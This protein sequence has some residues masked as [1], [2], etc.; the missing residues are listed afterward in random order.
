MV[1]E[2][3]GRRARIVVGAKALVLGDTDDGLHVSFEIDRTLKPEPNTAEIRIWNL[4]ESSRKLLEQMAGV[5]PLGIPVSVEAGYTE[6]SLLFLGSMREAYS[7]TQWADIV[8]TIRT[9]EGEQAYQ[10]S[11]ANLS[12]PRGT[13]ITAALLQLAAQLGVLPG[14]LAAQSYQFIGGSTVFANGAVFSGNAAWEITSLLSACGKE[15][16]IQ[17]GQIQVLDRNKAML[18]TAVFM[19]AETGMIDAPSISNKGELQARM[20]LVPDVVPGRLLVAKSRHV[21]GTFRIE[22]CHYSGDTHGGDWAVEITG[23]ALGGI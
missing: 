9:G 13:P 17:N 18:S 15:W 5:K 22:K 11:R 8:T 14:N 2:L 3:F 19:S 12:L 16:S 23:Q 7:E 6:P 4:A 10:T 21:N 1:N 20:L